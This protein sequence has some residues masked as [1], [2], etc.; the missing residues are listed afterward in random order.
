MFCHIIVVSCAMAAALICC[1]GTPRRHSPV[2]CPSNV[3]ERVFFV[4]HSSLPASPLVFEPW[5]GGDALFLIRSGGFG[6]PQGSY[7][8]N[9]NR[10]E[11]ELHAANVGSP[12]WRGRSPWR[13]LYWDLHSASYEIKSQTKCI[14]S[15]PRHPSYRGA[16]RCAYLFTYSRTCPG[17]AT[18]PV[19]P[20]P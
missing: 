15:P 18:Q 4:P 8:K 17:R 3:V 2:F 1:H 11:G 20:G 13:G 19:I 9:K 7:R 16:Q 14:V 12:M 5:F 6:C 10:G